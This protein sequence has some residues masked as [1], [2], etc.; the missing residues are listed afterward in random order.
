MTLTGTTNPGQSGHGSNG[1]E[2]VLHILQSS[3][4]SASTSD[5]L[6][7]YPGYSFVGGAPY[8]FAEIQLAYSKT[9]YI[10][11]WALWPQVCLCWTMAVPAGRQVGKHSN[12]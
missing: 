8:T 1:N 11:H 9:P 3:R 7:P 5:C 6:V 4:A 10:C 2:G 12:I